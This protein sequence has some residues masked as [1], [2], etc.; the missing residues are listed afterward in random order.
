MRLIYHLPEEN[1]TRSPFDIAIIDLIKNKSIKVAC[2]YIGLDYFQNSIVNQCNDFSLLTDVNELFFSCRNDSAIEELMSFIHDN[3]ERI[4]H[5]SGLHSKV[6]ISDT[7]AFFGSANLT[8]S[9]ITE[10]N[11]LSAV[12]NN[13]ADI[14]LLDTWFDTWWRIGS[15]LDVDSIQKKLRENKK[16][17]LLPNK[18][19]ISLIDSKRLI[20]TTYELLKSENK[21]M[22]LTQNEESLIN[23]LKHWDNKDWMSSYFDLAKHILQKYNIEVN[24]QRLCISFRR[25][26]YRIPITIGQRYILAPHYRKQNSIGLIMPIKYD[27]ENTK[28]EGAFLTTYFTKNK[29]NDVAW[30]H[31]DKGIGKFHFNSITFKEWEYAV[32]EELNKSKISSFR[33]YHQPILYKFI[34]DENYRKAIIDE[35]E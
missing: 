16:D 10:R 30:V 11:E 19:K 6:I 8:K 22:D 29:S 12:I 23:F 4:R 7:K 3:S 32:E 9:G 20:K 24:D 35:L 21:Q 15:I 31:Y 13:H 1:N 2:P 5:I 26:K 14:A 28:N 17:F 18:M 27:V 34:V 33:K 25:D